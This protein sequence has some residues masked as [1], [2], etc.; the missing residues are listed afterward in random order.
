MDGRFYCTCDDKGFQINLKQ[1]QSYSGILAVLFIEKLYCPIFA[2]RTLQL[3]SREHNNV[4]K[5]ANL[6]KGK[7]EIT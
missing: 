2:L 7:A 6:G 3:Q 1:I 5:Y 4:A